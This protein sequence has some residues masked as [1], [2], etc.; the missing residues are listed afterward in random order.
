MT[1]EAV[2][3]KL[4]AYHDYEL[5]Q[6]E[7]IKVAEHLKSC[8][9]CQ[10]EE[11]EIKEIIK[12]SQIPFKLKVSGEFINEVR[13]KAKITKEQT[14]WLAK[15]INF[16]T[17]PILRKSVISIAAALVLVVV[18]FKI[19][20]S[21]QIGTLHPS[22]NLSGTMT[23]ETADGNLKEVS[24][25]SGLKAGTTVMAKANQNIV[26][27]LS[28]SS[29]L[30]LCPFS[31][32]KFEGAANGIRQFVNVKNGGIYANVAKGDKQFL[33]KTPLCN[34]NVIGTEFYVHVAEK[35]TVITAIQG[36]VEVTNDFG[37]VQLAKG[38]Q[39]EV[40]TNKAPL[41]F[42]GEDSSIAVIEAKLRK[43]AKNEL[44]EKLTD[45]KFTISEFLAKFADILEVD[46]LLD[47]SD[48]TTE[49]TIVHFTPSSNT[50]RAI[51][52]D[53]LWKV[54]LNYEVTANGIRVYEI[55][56]LSKP[57]KETKLESFP[58]EYRDLIRAYFDKISKHTKK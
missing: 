39:V 6:R 29:E 57:S 13:T 54:N 16:L 34:V 8:H 14:G 58:F 41:L 36:I 15:L 11:K 53:V 50:F 26:I 19:F 25:N 1:C 55:H 3:S 4:V 51:L 2:K 42:R 23:I 40:V 5:S 27:K 9:A 24:V 43:V 45:N 37:K 7:S 33:V 30:T 21:K 48:Y 52:E 28:D 56:K 38:E 12:L 49:K 18:G 32:V 35:S 31:V 44:I 10:S 20:S 47:V 46:M 17:L 22:Y